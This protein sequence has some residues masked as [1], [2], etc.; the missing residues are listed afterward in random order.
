[1]GS[2]RLIRFR[3]FRDLRLWIGFLVIELGRWAL[4]ASRK[5]D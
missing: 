5:R 1:M 4:R 3:R 2:R